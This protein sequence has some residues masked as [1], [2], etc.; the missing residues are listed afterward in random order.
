MAPRSAAQRSAAQRSA[1]QRNATQR[2]AT[3][4]QRIASQPA[5]REQ[6]FASQPARRV[7]NSAKRNDRTAHCITTSPPRLQ[8]SEAERSAAQPSAAQRPQRTA[9]SPRT[10]KLQPAA[11][12]ASIA[13]LL[14]GSWI[15]MVIKAHK[16]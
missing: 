13:V 16:T 7:C 10:C 6:R 14:F 4:A 11:P 12:S 15:Y 3:T 2:N 1:A 9:H 5:R 8:R